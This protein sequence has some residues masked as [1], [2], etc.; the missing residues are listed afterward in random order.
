MNYNVET[1]PTFDRQLK[2]LAKKFLS[3]KTDLKEL[4]DS[5]AE[6]PTQGTSLGNNC[7]KI[8]L[9]IRSKGR[10][11]SGGSRV[12]THVRVE[13]ETV[14]LLSIYDKSERSNLIEGELDNLLTEVMNE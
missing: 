2:R 1:I 10:G 11:K 4:T 12:V 14:Y 6:T 8:R 3:L 9:S 5:L 7:Y 13:G